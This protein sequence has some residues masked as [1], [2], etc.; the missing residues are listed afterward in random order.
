MRSRQPSESDTE[1]FARRQS[2]HIETKDSRQSDALT[3]SSTLGHSP[4]HEHSVNEWLFPR[5]QEVLIPICGK[6]TTA[7]SIWRCN[8]STTR[9]GHAPPKYART[10]IDARR[11]DAGSAPT[12]HRVIEKRRVG[13]SNYSSLQEEENDPDLTWSDETCLV[14]TQYPWPQRVDATNTSSA[15]LLI[16]KRCCP[17]SHY[18]SPIRT[19]SPRM[20]F[21]CSLFQIRLS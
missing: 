13:V 5:V 2:H 20:Y 10:R 18:R 4:G 12:T 1:R 11:E 6:S 14:L 9:R 15:L 7:T 21:S 17:M 19:H 3:L 16:A 8:R